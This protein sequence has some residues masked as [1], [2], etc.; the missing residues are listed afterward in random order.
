MND[1]QKFARYVSQQIL[2]MLGLSCYILADTFFI[3]E[4]LGTS[5]LASL[6]LAI[7]VYLSLIHI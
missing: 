5:G 7:S 1:R 2:G 4:G 3:S 6:N